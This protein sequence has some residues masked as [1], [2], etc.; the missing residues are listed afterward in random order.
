M[1]RRRGGKEEDLR[2][3]CEALLYLG[4]GTALLPS[5]PST[6]HGRMGLAP[7]TLVF[8]NLLGWAPNPGKIPA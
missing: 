4:P 7:Q 1:L 8:A 3:I 5:W 6:L 2:R